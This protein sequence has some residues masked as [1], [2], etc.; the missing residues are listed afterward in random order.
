MRMT[1]DERVQLAR[2]NASLLAAVR[3]QRYHELNEPFHA[4]IYTG[5]HN[6]YLARLAAETRARVAPLPRSVPHG[7]RSQA[8]HESILDAIGS[9][10]AQAASTAMRRHI[11]NVYDAYGD[12]VIGI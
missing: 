11:E 8:E 1:S 2:I 9:N 7:A 6:T 10:E 5:S 3:G 4:A 12:Y